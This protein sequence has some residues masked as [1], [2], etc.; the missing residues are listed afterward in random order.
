MKGTKEIIK[1]GKIEDILLTFAETAKEDLTTSDLQGIAGAEALKIWD[2][3]R[4]QEMEQIKI[5]SRWGCYAR[6]G[7]KEYQ[8]F[9]NDNGKF[10]Y[11]I[12][13]NKSMRIKG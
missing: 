8:I 6:I 13:D 4:G 11:I 1:L 7:E 2:I 10:E 12:V 9:W 5:D 3:T